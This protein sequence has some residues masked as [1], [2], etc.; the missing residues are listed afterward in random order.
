VGNIDNGI[1]LVLDG[2]TE[3]SEKIFFRKKREKKKKIN[4]H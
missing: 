2:F 1:I 3:I 4:N